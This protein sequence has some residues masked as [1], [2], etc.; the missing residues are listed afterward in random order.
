[1]DFYPPE[2]PQLVDLNVLKSLRDEK[3]SEYMNSLKQE[4]QSVRQIANKDKQDNQTMYKDI[5]LKYVS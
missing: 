1:M 5:K 4:I 3:L 2:Q